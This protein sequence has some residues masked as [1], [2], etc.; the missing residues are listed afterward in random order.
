M[1]WR[2]ILPSSSRFAYLGSEN[3]FVVHT[4]IYIYI[5]IYTDCNHKT[6]WKGEGK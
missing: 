2:N 6:Y 5:Y 3:A 1:F 4:D